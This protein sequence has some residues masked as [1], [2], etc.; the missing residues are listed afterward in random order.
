M[1]ALDSFE[2][3]CGSDPDC[4]HIVSSLDRVEREISLAYPMIKDAPDSDV[5]EQPKSLA[6]AAPVA[7]AALKARSAAMAKNT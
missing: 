2:R 1:G 4:R 5:S 7:K 3:S 6:Q